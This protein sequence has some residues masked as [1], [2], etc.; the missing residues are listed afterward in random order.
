MVISSGKGYIFVRLTC[1]SGPL[2]ITCLMSQLFKIN[3]LLNCVHLISQ[4]F[5]LALYFYKGGKLLKDKST[6][7]LDL[8][9]I[10][11]EN[12]IYI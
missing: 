2:K 7:D 10:F 8:L 12:T 4:L 11:L 5:D 6:R 3:R 1:E 9:D